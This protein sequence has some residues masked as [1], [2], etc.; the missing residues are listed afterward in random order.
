M[1]PHEQYPDINVPLRSDYWDTQYFDEEKKAVKNF[2]TAKVLADSIYRKNRITSLEL[3]YPRFIHSEFMTHRMFSRNASS[4]RAT[5]VATLVKQVTEDPAFF[6]VVG[7]NKPGMQAD[8]EI[9]TE[10]FRKFQDEWK[11]LANICAGYALRWSQEYN[12]HKQVAN[13]VLEPFMYMKT[14]VTATNWNN[15]FNLRL[16]KDAQ[17]DIQDL[18]IAIYFAIKKS[19]P[20]ETNTHLPYISDEE[21]KEDILKKYIMST[22]RCARVSYLTFDNKVPTFEQDRK[23]F[24]KLVT[25]EPMH[26]SP[27]EHVA[28]ALEGIYDN[29]YGWCS[30]RNAI[31]CDKKF[32]EEL[33]LI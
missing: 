12:I 19:I 21:Q 2:C 13:R 26:A 18:A 28:I 5:P 15:F 11:E 22:A 20:V 25:S 8:I 33:L 30:L 32:K 14:V 10:N 16:H 27:L 6:G 29:F 24:H 31:T 1:A 9:D 17:P 23:L 3:R 4:S 7:Q